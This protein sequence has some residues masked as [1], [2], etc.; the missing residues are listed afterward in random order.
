[1]SK[2][3]EKTK[4]I[5]LPLILGQQSLLTKKSQTILAA[6]IAMFAMVAEFID[7]SGTRIGISY[8]DRLFLKEKLFAPSSMK[9]F[10]GHYK[11]DKW[12]AVWAHTTIPI[13]SENHVPLRSSFGVDI[14]NTQTTT[15]VIG[16]LY[17]HL[18]SSDISSLV[19]KYRIVGDM[20]DLIYNI[21]PVRQSPLAWPPPRTMTD[22]DA[23]NIASALSERARR[24]AKLGT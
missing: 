9:I 13:A 1:M 18:V 8:E 22:L 15:F 20:R 14:P 5:L 11:K 21:H 4:P 23:D 24:I 2:L 10:I 6:W 7:K 19:R 3:Q 16:K 17:I 12:L